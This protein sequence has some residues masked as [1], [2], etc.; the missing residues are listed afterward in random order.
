MKWI[1]IEGG[2]REVRSINRYVGK[3]S[4]H[5]L[6]L[7]NHLYI[8]IQLLGSEDWENIYIYVCIFFLRNGKQHDEG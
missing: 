1:I 2:S 7:C 3:E 4:P 8:N 5:L 6:V